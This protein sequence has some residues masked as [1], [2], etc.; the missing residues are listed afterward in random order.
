M[1]KLHWIENQTRV[2]IDRAVTAKERSGIPMPGPTNPVDE[3]RLGDLLSDP[4][5]SRSVIGSRSF[6]VTA[7]AG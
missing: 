6:T 7:L 5:M 2:A 1:L 4:N 3:S